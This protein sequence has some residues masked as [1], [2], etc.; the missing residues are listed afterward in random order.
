M[1]LDWPPILEWLK[2]RCPK[3]GGEIGPILEEPSDEQ[4]RVLYRKT[5]H[6]IRA[7]ANA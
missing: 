1:S 2:P 4:A 5:R 7:S 6:R 3:L